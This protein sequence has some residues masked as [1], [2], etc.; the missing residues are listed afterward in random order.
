MSIFWGSVSPAGQNGL[1][2]ALPLRSGAVPV[3]VIVVIVVAAGLV[4]L[5]QPPE[6]VVTLLAGASAV[7]GHLLQYLRGETD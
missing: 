4:V 6:S 1:D 2:P 7:A 5:G 3:V